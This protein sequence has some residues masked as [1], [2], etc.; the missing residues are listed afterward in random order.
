MISTG[1]D[2]I[3]LNAINITRTKQPRFYS[4]IL[5]GAER[6]LYNTPEFAAI[7]LASFVWLLWSVK[8]SAYKFLKRIDPEL[9]FTPIKFEVE[10]LHVPATFTI[11]HVEPEEFEGLGFDD[12]PV[13]KGI[14]S[15]GDIKLYSRSLVYDNLILS[16]VNSTDD[17]D[18]IYW[19]IKSIGNADHHTQSAAVREFLVA[20]LQNVLDDEDITISKTPQ[21]IPVLL[22]GGKVT[23]IPV[24]LSHH[25]HLIAYSFQLN[26]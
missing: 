1:N 16:V 23:Q 18:N 14:L 13:L 9:V 2:I 22:S 3:S 19:G 20:S 7:P 15:K 5:S 10:Q 11:T 17:F 24:S 6:S 4:K 25:E 12:R 21:G 8:E 26:K